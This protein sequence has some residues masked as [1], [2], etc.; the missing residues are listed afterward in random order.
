MPS[1]DSSESELPKENNTSKSTQDDKHTNNAKKTVTQ[2]EFTIGPYTPAKDELG[3][4]KFTRHVANY[5]EDW[6]KDRSLVAAIYGGWGEGKTFLKDR[7][8][9]EIYGE[10][11]LKNPDEAIPVVQYNPWRW[12][13]QDELYKG[14][15]QTLEER[16]RD[17]GKK[18]GKSASE[19]RSLADDAN[20][21]AARGG[22][23]FNAA[24]AIGSIFGLILGVASFLGINQIP[25]RFYG[26][27][28]QL[29]E[30][31]IP[32]FFFIDTFLPLQE[33]KICLMILALGF[34]GFWVW[35]F[36]KYNYFLA[37]ANQEKKTLGEARRDIQRTL[38]D[39]HEEGKTI[40]I[41]VDDIDRLAADQI[42]MMMQ[43]V[44]ANANFVGVK[45]LLLFERQVV[46]QSLEDKENGINGRDFL[47]KIVRR[48]F[49]LPA[50]PTSK[51]LGYFDDR[52]HEG[53]GEQLTGRVQGSLTGGAFRHL[54][55]NYLLH[56]LSTIRDVDRLLD[57]LILHLKL[58]DSGGRRL[59][60]HILDL[61]C[62]EVIR[63]FEP[64]LFREMQKFRVEL[65][66]T[67]LRLED[68]SNDHKTH[69]RNVQESL[70][71]T[72]N[73]QDI[74]TAKG[75]L[76]ELFPLLEWAEIASD[77][78]SWAGPTSEWLAQN[79]I[80]HR[81]NFNRYFERALGEGDVSQGLVD[82]LLYPDGDS[83]DES[84]QIWRTLIRKGK[85]E[86]VE[87]ALHKLAHRINEVS[88]AET[89]LI[90][91]F[92]AADSFSCKSRNAL[93]APPQMVA[94]DIVRKVLEQ[95]TND[96]KS[97]EEL[98]NSVLDSTSSLFFS[99]RVVREI[100]IVEKERRD[101]P[102]EEVTYSD[103]TIEKGRDH[104]VAK[105]KDASGKGSLDNEHLMYLMIRWYRWGDKQEPRNW[106]QSILG[107]DN[108]NA[109]RV[110]QGFRRGATP[111]ESRS[112]YR[113]YSIPSSHAI[114]VE[115]LDKFG[116]LETMNEL[117]NRPDD[118][119]LKDDEKDLVHM[120]DVALAN[121][122]GGEKGSQPERAQDIDAQDE[123][124][125]VQV[126][127]SQASPES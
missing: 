80:T 98:L 20:A 60:I 87:N 71:N 3:R 123:S 34:L 49:D 75:L 27:T 126:E 120:F 67:A 36:G 111:E 41:V 16:F 64:D 39:L 106:L 19:W 37:K 115:W 95:K 45:Y 10:D 43:L 35:K 96:L 127:D 65:T 81:T 33:L 32:D 68:Y 112:T 8:L 78:Q 86:G 79:R 105:L 12:S 25:D 97:R 29:S 54:L 66:V 9:E 93:F 118:K 28:P 94:V 38:R 83:F 113:E 61:V 124:D 22:L 91:L 77:T 69:L 13:G 11:K 104:C 114:A 5:I 26:L 108:E 23:S 89:F 62:I 56:Y 7:I 100:A 48:G 40:L 122:R 17:L 103:A 92:K 50:I 88:D 121:Y 116:V 57:T 24:S 109:F 51:L 107:Q 90:A 110:L 102:N 2:G 84:M 119:D 59:D 55:T 74:H 47:Q 42:R 72:V 30:K 31:W 82:K 21:V 101:D 58:Y 4:E 70:L 63:V 44:K 53:I 52:L 1:K 99:C 15:F 76:H 73:Q 6:D 14:F 125:A 18:K 117:V 85:G 46:E